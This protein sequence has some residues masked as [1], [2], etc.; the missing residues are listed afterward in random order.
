MIEFDNI[1]EAMKFINKADFEL[2]IRKNKLIK[3]S[4]NEEIGVINFKK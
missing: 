1:K 2:T 3:S 4:T